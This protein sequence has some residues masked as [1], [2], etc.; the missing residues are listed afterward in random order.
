MLI[1][2]GPTA[3]PVETDLV[4]GKALFGISPPDLVGS[5]VVKAGAGVK[6]IGAEFQKTPFA[7]VSMADK[8]ITTPRDMIGKKIGGHAVSEPLWAA[9]LSA[10]HINPNTIT[11]GPEQCD[12][13]PLTTAPADG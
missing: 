6:I 3:T 2:G 9:V 7:L 8:P 13:L 4:A 10:N 1:S 12:P 5:A 11:N